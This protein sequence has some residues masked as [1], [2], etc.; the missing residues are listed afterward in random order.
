MTQIQVR[1]D[2]KTKENARKILEKI[3]LDLS[4]GIKL[5]CRQVVLKKTLP[6][7]IRDENGFTPKKAAELREAI[8]DA[9][10]GKTFRSVEEL[11]ADLES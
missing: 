11:M 2:T 5:F 7:D 1:I 6:F 10:K 3:G 9:R 8:R 4:T